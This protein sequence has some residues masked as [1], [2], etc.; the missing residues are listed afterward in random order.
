MTILWDETTC[1]CKKAVAARLAPCRNGFDPLHCR[2][3]V[4]LM[5][6]LC[7]CLH[8][9]ALLLGTC[10]ANAAASESTT[11]TSLVITHVTVID[12]G[13][14]TV[15]PNQTVVISGDTILQV[16]RTGSR[17]GAPPQAAVIDASGKYLIPGLWD[18]HAHVLDPERE[19]ALFLA[20]GVTGLRNIGGVAKD[21][22]KWRDEV[23]A[24]TTLG[25][26]MIACGPILDGPRP[27]TPEYSVPIETPEEG[28]AAVR[29]QKTE[30]AEFLKIYDG[31]SRESYLAIA[32]EAKK[33]K[34]PFAGHV[35]V[36]VTIMDATDA[37]QHSIEHGIELRGTST[38]EDEVI[39][40]I[41][42]T[43]VMAEALRTKNFALIPESIAR[44]GNLLLDNYSVSRARQLYRALVK[45]H[46]Y[47][48]PTL[49]TE[50]ALTFVDDLSQK[51]DP[52][53]KYI[54]PSSREYW[55][56][57]KGMLTR[58]RTPAYKE[59]RKR[60]FAKMLK[61]VAAAHQAGVR[62]LAGTDT[63]LPYIYP[64]FSVHDELALFVQAGFTRLQALQTA[65]SNPA[66][67]FDVEKSAG[68]IQPGMAAD[69][70]LLDAD[71]IKD[72]ANTTR[73][74]AVI[75][76]GRLLPRAVLDRMLR[77]AEEMVNK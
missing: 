14:G 27:A 73:I 75:V 3:V 38:A 59:F 40:L 64:G 28:R 35:P 76:R 26:W 5:M 53:A 77:R 56:P 36:R 41:E 11:P 70:V 47:L 58:Y 52:R 25:P 1:G 48:T 49:V 68:G 8:L 51:D 32:E 19:F 34:L 22:F 17:A 42:T 61:H 69:L 62:F 71:P 37:G 55:K 4:L 29:A 2:G 13:E 6:K 63:S 50:H 33:L 18:M 43:D 65:T 31:L 10:A 24:G 7:T 39:R 30:G 9:A 60:E 74:N 57:E 16:V 15:R 46:T 67:Y 20:N 12:P 21:V 54:P 44:R 23:R 66:S 45:H 72:I